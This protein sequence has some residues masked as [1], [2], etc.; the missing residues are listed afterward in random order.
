M[1][2]KNILN[3][4]IRLNKFLSDSGVCSRREADRIIEAGRVEIDGH[5]AII[6]E[7][8][9]DGALVCVDK[10]AVKP[11]ENLILLALNKPIGIE[12]T[13]DR[14]NKDNVIDF[15]QYPSRLIYVGRLDKNSSG[16]LLMTNDGELA[17]K[18]AKSREGHEKEYIVRVNKRISNEFL[19]KMAAGV[20][21]LDTITRPC[22]IW[23]KDDYSFHI[24]LTQGLNRQIR[25]MCEAL[26]Y[27]VLELERIRVMNI[28][29]NRLKVGTYRKVTEAEIKDLKNLL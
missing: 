27:K 15:I 25:R 14:Q 3:N 28:K 7:R 13:C 17:N 4:G 23:K 12:C 26:H 22:Q 9:K 16:L 20:A 18:I 6:G 24:I 11:K 21:I 2:E 19:E 1:A 8:V 5:V 29:L 10:K